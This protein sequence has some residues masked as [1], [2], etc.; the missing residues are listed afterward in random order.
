MVSVDGL[1]DA[2]EVAVRARIEELRV[3]LADA[4]RD[5][6]HV[7][8]TRNTLQVVVKGAGLIR[9]PRAGKAVEGAVSDQ[10]PVT[11]SGPEPTVVPLR[12]EGMTEQALPEGYR[13][14]WLVARSAGEGVRAG[15]LA[16]ALELPA[17][18]SVREGL[19]SKLKRMVARG[20]AVEAAPGVFRMV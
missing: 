11:F 15:Q 13:S 18:D 14:M 19:R 8:I 5:L 12:G 10:A 6:E 7:V 17:T 2:H 20:W 3:Q 16:R 1:L 4:E 9:L